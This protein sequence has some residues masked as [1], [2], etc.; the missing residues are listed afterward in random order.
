MLVSSNANARHL[1]TCG[2]SLLFQGEL[3]AGDA[4]EKPTKLAGWKEIAAFVGREV[5]TVQRWERELGLPVHRVPGSRGHSVFAHPEEIERWFE[6]G[7]SEGTLAQKR[8]RQFTLKSGYPSS[9]GSVLRQAVEWPGTAPR[10]AH[11]SLAGTT[12]RLRSRTAFG[13]LVIASVA[14]FLYALSGHRVM[15]LLGSGQPVITSVTP[16]LP[17]ADQ[18]IVILGHGMGT[19]TSFNNLDTPYLAIRDKTAQW[20][21]GRIIP[22]NQDEV[23]L[24]VARWTDSE[25]VVTGLAGAYGGNNWVLNPS[26]KIE[27]ALWNPQTGAGPALYHLNVTAAVGAAPGKASETPGTN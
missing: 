15:T 22:E 26:D 12:W 10:P 6:A 7:S 8:L 20:A 2:A 4:K 23:T 17:E 3:M 14:I 25:I 18:T 21:A 27:V 9:G 11:K 13:A 19:Y 24:N 1:T 5:R 16:I